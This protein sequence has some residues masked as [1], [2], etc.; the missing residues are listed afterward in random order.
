ML[1]AA[2]T[3]ALFGGSFG[4]FDTDTAACHITGAPTRPVLG[5]SPEQTANAATIVAVGKR[6]Q[7]PERGLVT[8]LAAALQESGLRN[9]DH[10][11][12]DSLG[13]FQQR[14][15][16]G[17]GTPAEIMNPAY[18]ATAFYRRLL[19]VR[20]WHELSVNDA[21]QTVQRSATPTAYAQH[22]PAARALTAAVGGATCNPPAAP[23]HA[24]AAAIAFA[25]D[26]IGLP[27]LWGG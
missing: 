18:A 15:S 9:L 27:Y 11:D 16:Q 25:H 5:Y 6:I 1:M 23:T 7:V 13:L 4:G 2:A 19:E 26:Q 17:W 12:R 10:G 3:T 8:A 21:A 14:P 20:D 22:E 24:A